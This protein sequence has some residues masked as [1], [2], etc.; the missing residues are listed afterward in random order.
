[1]CY[2]ILFLISV[3]H[4]CSAFEPEIT[5]KLNLNSCNNP[6]H[7]QP[8]HSSAASNRYLHNQSLQQSYSAEPNLT[9]YS[10]DQLTQYFAQQGYSEDHIL[11]RHDLYVNPEFIKLIKTYAEYERY[12]SS[13]H[14]QLQKKSGF[15]KWIGTFTG[16]HTKGLTK[17][18]AELCK[19]VERE[20]YCKNLAAQRAKRIAQTT[21]ITAFDSAT[22]LFASKYGISEQHFFHTTT[23]VYEQQLHQEFVTQLSEGT[24]LTETYKNAA[25]Y[26]VFLDA[27]GHGVAIGLEANQSHNIVAA[28]RWADYGWAILD[29]VKGI[30]EGVILGACNTV[31]SVM[32]TVSH[33]IQTAHQLIHGIGTIAYFL[34]QA[35]NTALK[36]ER[37]IEFGDYKTFSI[38]AK[39][40]SDQLNKVVQNSRDQL[41]LMS[42]KEI[43]RRAVAFGTELVLTGK[44]LTMA[45]NICTR[46]TPLALDAVKILRDE[47]VAV[48]LTITTAEGVQ[49][50]SPL[51]LF[52]EKELELE[53]I[54]QVIATPAPKIVSKSVRTILPTWVDIKSLMKKFEDQCIYKGQSVCVD[55]EHLFSIGEMHIMKRSGRMKEPRL[56]GWHHDHMKNLEKAGIVQYENIVEGACGAFKAEPVV[57]GTKYGKKTFFS[58]VWTEEQ[59]V[60]KILE[61]LSNTHISC[62]IDSERCEVIEALTRCGLKVKIVY[63]PRISTI[64]TAFPIIE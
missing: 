50:T 36:F 47:Q 30:G 19:G 7:Q 29:V 44:V 13:L 46:L 40:L 26:K 17:R 28:T 31:N 63:D 61:A 58:P 6:T 23:N 27:L 8:N 42:Q 35:T 60:E 10:V 56:Y 5:V 49:E 15:A 16:T 14:S 33:P 51:M 39:T 57:N 21:Q 54:A 32:Q 24:K 59:V 55:C 1:M 3:A 25:S 4:T 22:L 9:I 34:A 53:K 52:M 48:E 45:H 20:K 11:Q 18:I 37:L 62:M 64:T 12:I 38:E 2:S 41:A 43:A